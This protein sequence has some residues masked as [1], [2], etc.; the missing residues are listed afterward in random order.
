MSPLHLEVGMCQDW[1]DLNHGGFPFSSLSNQ[2]RKQ[3]LSKRHTHT[4]ICTKY[5]V[6]TSWL[7]QVCRSSL[8]DLGSFNPWLTRGY[9]PEL[10][11]GT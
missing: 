8:E 6:F 9:E 11:S 5:K 2:P 3:V 1:G 10:Q 4:N 7:H